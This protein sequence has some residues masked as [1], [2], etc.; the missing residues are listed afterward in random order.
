MKDRRF[1]VRMIQIKPYTSNKTEYFDFLKVLLTD[2][3][4]WKKAAELLDPVLTFL[5]LNNLESCKICKF[6]IV[7]KI[8]F[9][10]F[11]YDNDVVRACLREI[12][13]N[14]DT[15]QLV[16]NSTNEA[17][18]EDSISRKNNIQYNPK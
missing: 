17:N 10:W 13:E 5:I 14:S 9:C 7:S 6:K 15:C 8:A 11:I 2:L 4:I 16:F 3:E 1:A 12:K 18:S